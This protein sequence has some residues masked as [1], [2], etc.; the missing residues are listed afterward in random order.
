MA[1]MEMSSPLAAI[2]R[3]EHNWLQPTPL[4][5]A[6]SFLNQKSA[7]SPRLDVL[8]DSSFLDIE[9]TT[10]PTDCLAA[11]LSQNFHIDK[12]PAFPTPRRSLFSAFG[13]IDRAA[14]KTPPLPSSP[15]CSDIMEMSPLPHKPAFARNQSKLKEVSPPSPILDSPCQMQRRPSNERKKSIPSRRPSL[16]RAKAYTT[17][18]VL[19]TAGMSK[20]GFS[21]QNENKPF[22]FGSKKSSPVMNL[23]EMFTVSPENSRVGLGLNLT[24]SRPKMPVFQD[25]SSPAASD[26]SPLAAARRYNQRPARK[27][28]CRRTMSMFNN[29]EEVISPKVKA[30]P[31]FCAQSPSQVAARES[32]IL[33]C[34]SNNKDTLKRISRDTMVDV[35]D[36]KY[37]G[38]YDQMKV[39]D[40]RF[41]YEFKGG[42]IAG[43]IN[44][45]T[46]E[47]V[48]KV[49]FSMGSET[50]VETKKTLLILHCE[51]SAH[52]APRIANHLR[53]RDRQLN[54]HRYPELHY[55][56]IYIL[57]GGYSGFFTDHKD[58]CE[59]QC[60]VE[61]D[62][63][64]HKV[65][66]E[67]ELGKFRRNTK[68]GRAQSYT[69]GA[70]PLANKDSPIVRR[71][72]LA[73]TT[74][75]LNGVLGR[76]RGEKLRM[77]SY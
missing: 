21:G 47:D 30:E 49:L 11:D 29:A 64:R 55:P 39:I 36:G 77:T 56:E 34:F 42:H 2:S 9:M 61:M 14:V 3:P 8:N 23:D 58:R 7:F 50:K 67:R 51:Y 54:M 5:P 41:E 43:A 22:Q 68:F 37:S 59:P 12:T 18:M 25:S 40:C 72:P 10:S 76:P 57:D 26:G 48:D 38:K 52:R 19:K 27:M 33:P 69:F 20:M 73:Q 66:C 4:G 16:Q 44:I 70:G 65:L 13:N 62:D 60:Y 75:G 35:L 31:K 6:I 32:Q 46:L 17:N 53:A 71:A 45:N 1:M 15:A 24:G 28:A 74:F 63:S